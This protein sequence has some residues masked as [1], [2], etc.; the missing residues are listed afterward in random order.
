MSSGQRAVLDDYF[1]LKHILISEVLYDLEFIFSYVS[2]FEF[3]VSV[4]L[5]SSLYSFAEMYLVVL[6]INY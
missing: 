6:F 2:K 1:V 3:K 4:I 5:A